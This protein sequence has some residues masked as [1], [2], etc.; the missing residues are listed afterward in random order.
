MSFLDLELDCLS[1]NQMGPAE[2]VIRSKDG[3]KMY[4]VITYK[5]GGRFHELK[6]PLHFSSYF[7]R[8]PIFVQHP[9]GKFQKSGLCLKIGLFCNY[10]FLDRYYLTGYLRY[11]LACQTVN[12][13]REASLGCVNVQR[14]H[15]RIT[16]CPIRPKNWYLCPKRWAD[17]T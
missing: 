5:R 3:T 13:T 15:C 17:E 6:V 12:I 1:Y 9:Y 14:Y 8:P 7:A 16:T 4:L 11:R 10:Y 2:E